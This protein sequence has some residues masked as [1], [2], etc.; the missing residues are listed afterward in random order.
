VYSCPPYKLEESSSL[1]NQFTTSEDTELYKGY[2]FTEPD[3][4]QELDSEA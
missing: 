3:L 4:G 2:G 1:P